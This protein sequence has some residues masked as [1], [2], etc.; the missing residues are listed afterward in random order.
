[1]SA[2]VD[3]ARSSRPCG[4]FPHVRN[5]VPLDRDQHIV[6]HLSCLRLQQTAAAHQS[7]WRRSWLV[8]PAGF[9]LTAS[10]QHHCC[11]NQED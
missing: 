2:K 3:D 11:H 10:A 4:I 7:N 8:R 5:A 9:F 1:M 6:L